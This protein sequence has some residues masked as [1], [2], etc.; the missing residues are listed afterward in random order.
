[1]EK[2]S[3]DMFTALNSLAKQLNITVDH[4]WGVMVTQAKITG[5]M[6]TAGAILSLISMGV[7]LYFAIKMTARIRAGKTD[8]VDVFGGVVALWTGF[9]ALLI[10]TTIF[11]NSLAINLFNPEYW[12]LIKITSIVSRI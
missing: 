8:D 7:C 9:G 6:N 1:M 3:T 2:L 12:A 5:I 10:A 11:I 4:L